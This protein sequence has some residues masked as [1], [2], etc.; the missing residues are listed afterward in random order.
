MRDTRKINVI[1]QG[2]SYYVTLPKWMM[3]ELRWK[4]GQ[5][6]VVTK[7]YGKIVLRIEI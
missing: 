4:K 2:K 7:K 6:V 5:K 3:K 1:G